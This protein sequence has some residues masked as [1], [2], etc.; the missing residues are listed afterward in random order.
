MLIASFNALLEGTHV[1]GWVPTQ[2]LLF[3]LLQRTLGAMH[4]AGVRP[5]ICTMVLIAAQSITALSATPR[6]ITDRSIGD[7]S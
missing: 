3:L 6:S 5:I 4:S 1:Q 2:G 7:G